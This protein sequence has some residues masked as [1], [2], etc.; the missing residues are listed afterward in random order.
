MH[1]YG[2]Q[3]SSL[4][5]NKWSIVSI[6]IAATASRQI[7]FPEMIPI[8]VHSSCSCLKSTQQQRFSHM[9]WQTNILC[10]HAAPISYKQAVC[11]SFGRKNRYLS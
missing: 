6:L 9:A 7:Q 4:K 10:R 3:I 8:L 1:R 2:A 11:S 5:L